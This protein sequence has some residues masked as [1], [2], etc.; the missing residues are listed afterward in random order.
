MR[1][2]LYSLFLMTA[3]IFGGP[4][5]GRGADVPE[6]S[7]FPAARS[8]WLEGSGYKVRYDAPGAISGDLLQVKTEILNFAPNKDSAGRPL[9]YWILCDKFDNNPAKG[10]GCIGRGEYKTSNPD[11]YYFSVHSVK[12]NDALL[13]EL[14]DA[15]KSLLSG[16]TPEA[17][18]AATEVFNRLKKSK[19]CGCEP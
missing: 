14:R 16:D 9:R 7:V 1:H 8:V 6:I 15:M 17:R 2:K 19:A 18:K 13:T 11:F 3:L 12:A 5:S 4:A 10:K